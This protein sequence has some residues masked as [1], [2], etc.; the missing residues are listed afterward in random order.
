MLIARAGAASYHRNNKGIL[1]R[2]GLVEKDIPGIVAEIE[3][4]KESLLF[5]RNHNGGTPT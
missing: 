2:Y 3:S 5:R 1:E 4:I